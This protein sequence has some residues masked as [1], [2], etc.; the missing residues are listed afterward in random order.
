MATIQF[1]PKSLDVFISTCILSVAAALQQTLHCLNSVSSCSL[2]PERLF[3]MTHFHDLRSVV[4]GYAQG[5]SFREV[6]VCLTLELGG[7]HRLVL[8][9]ECKK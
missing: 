2:T 8:A 3:T 1:T 9:T 6:R 7:K 5:K 4:A